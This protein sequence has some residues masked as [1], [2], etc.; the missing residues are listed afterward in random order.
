LPRWFDSA[1]HEFQ[2]PDQVTITESK[3]ER[4]SITATTD[5]RGY[6][7]LTDSWYPGWCAL[8]DGQ[9]AP[10]DRVDVLFRA[11]LI[12]PGSHTIVFEYRP[13]SFLIGAIISAASLI[14]LIVYVGMSIGRTK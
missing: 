8:V 4:V 13:D 7:V 14:I 10:I 9:L 1:H 12:E 6:L 5:Q 11:V 2:L 3:P